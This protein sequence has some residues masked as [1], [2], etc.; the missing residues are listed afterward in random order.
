MLKR[1]TT[2][3]ANRYMAV[4]TIAAILIL[5]T[6]LQSKVESSTMYYLTVRTDPPGI[7]TIGGEGWYAAGTIVSLTAPYIADGYQFNYWG[8]DGILIPGNPIFITM[9]S[10][11]TAIAH[12]KTLPVHNVNTGLNYTT[13]QA[14]ID[15]PQTIDG[16]T[17][18]CD[19][20]NYTENVDWY[21]SLKIIGA[22]AE[23]TW[24]I[25]F[26]PDDG[27]YVTASNV[28][29]KGF[30]IQSVSGYSGVFLDKVTHCDISDNIL[31]GGGSGI[32][33]KGSS[34]NTISGNR[35]YSLPGDGIRIGDS[36]QRNKISSNNLNQNHYGIEVRNASNYNVISDNFVNSSDWSGIKLNWQGAGF[37]SVMFNNITNNILCNNYEGITLDYPSNHNFVYN[38]FVTDNYIGIH[39]RQANDTSVVHNTVISNSYRGISAESSYANT[40]DDNFLNNTNNAWDNGANSWNITKQTGPNMIGGPYVG[41]NYWSDN[42]NPADAD[43][44]G[45]GDVPYN[46]LGGAN[47][48]YLPLVGKVNLTSLSNPKITPSSGQARKDTFTITAEYEDNIVP[49]NP[50]NFYPETCDYNA[51]AD[52]T[53]NDEHPRLAVDSKGNVHKVW[54]AEVSPGHWE[55]W[56]AQLI[57]SGPTQ[58]V[59]EQISDADVYNSTYPS[60]ALD[61]SDNSH[62]AWIDFR[63][64]SVDGV[65]VPNVA[66]IYYEKIMLDTG[67]RLPTGDRM[68]SNGGGPSDS[69]AS[70]R[71]VGFP[72]V[73]GTIVDS[74][75]SPEFIEHPD[76]A[77]DFLGQVH[78]V[79]SDKR[80]GTD[81]E[82]YYNKIYPSG[83]GPGT[84][85]LQFPHDLLLTDPT[86]KCGNLVLH[87]CDPQADNCDSIC[88]IIA[89]S[90]YSLHIAWQDKRDGCWEIYYQQRN[91]DDL[92]SIL[93]YNGGSPFLR[94][95]SHYDANY[96]NGHIPLGLEVNYPSGPGDPGSDGNNSAS[97]DIGVDSM[98]KK[99]G[100]VV[101]SNPLWTDT[102][103]TIGIGDTVDITAQGMWSW[104]G[105]IWVTPNGASGTGGYTDQFLAGANHGELIAF[106]GIDPYQDGKYGTSYFPVT[107]TGY[108]PIGS[109]KQFQSDRH[110]ELWLGFNDDARTQVISDNQGNVTANITV[111]G[112][113]EITWMDQRPTWW[114]GWQYTSGGTNTPCPT[115]WDPTRKQYYWEVYIAVL[116]S[117]GQLSYDP[118]IGGLAIKRES[119]M[120][121]YGGLGL[122]TSGPPYNQP[123]GYSMYPRMAVEPELTES[124]Q[125]HITWQDNR[126]ENWE[127]Y[128]KEITS[129]CKNPTPDKRASLPI[130]DNDIDMYPDIALEKISASIYRAHIKWQSRPIIGTPQTMVWRI[131]DTSRIIRTDQFPAPYMYAEIQPEG[132]PFPFDVLTFD[133]HP[134]IPSQNIT[135]GVPVTYGFTFILSTPGQYRFRICARDSAGY[136]CT[137]HWMEGPTVIP[138]HDIAIVNIAASKTIVG[139]GYSMAN[140]VTVINLGSSDEAFNVTLYANQTIIGTLTNVT[141][142]CGCRTTI[143]LSWNTTGFVK[144]NYTIWAYAWPVIG[145]IDKADN[146]FTDGWVIVTISGD[147]NGDRIVDISDLVITV[148]TIPSSPII[149]PENWNPNA[150]ING[151]GV[152]DVSDLVICVGNVPSGPW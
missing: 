93:D 35:I 146:T 87:P 85:A 9:D 50:P 89:C 64:Q 34:D 149:N 109:S 135:I 127:I 77:V 82:V 6:M 38:N 18:R 2:K 128:Y 13:I 53:S 121:P 72:P 49:Y 84:G 143:T 75:L 88:P 30:T 66:E 145:E 22:G 129:W 60:I 147:V 32:L 133:M 148:G 45:L 55:I 141:I 16:H 100:F 28:T 95:V 134:L 43:H 63:P 136:N 137:T 15:D 61:S 140:D 37:S 83:S 62:I 56:Y 29:I 151:D 131:F 126:D 130:L 74:P 119:D 124:S 118:L 107:D 113:V 70:G 25:P 48:D 76:I 54:M 96:D 59:Y 17:I 122:Y 3:N 10:N 102:G 67:T 81:W 79:W 139:K 71:A 47:K 23:L 8:V 116:Y 97:P 86:V 144:G 19:A 91:I 57:G 125:T 78:I 120:C 104:D 152:C 42:P 7:A 101:T 33:L 65:I 73:Y 114:Q 110:G 99:T 123:D 94:I 111:S 138:F 80:N 12:Y 24:I 105:S 98:P 44:D 69:F 39:L 1:R 106:V 41:G 26:E 51:T 4:A 112:R 11:K 142:P 5:S 36:S 90:G 46:V 20:G 52:P 27:F 103:L 150:D 115:V 132:I 117:W 92:H 14:A 58:K 40:I 21:K 68:I 31:T 108:W